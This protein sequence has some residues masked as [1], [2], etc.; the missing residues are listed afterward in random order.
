[1][2]MGWCWVWVVLAF[3]LVVGVTVG[4]MTVLWAATVVS[5]REAERDGELRER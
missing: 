4:V 2:I 1:V 3:A 5:G